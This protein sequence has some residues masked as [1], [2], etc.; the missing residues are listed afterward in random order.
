[1]AVVAKLVELVDLVEH[2]VMALP[3]RDLEGMEHCRLGLVVVGLRLHRGSPME[4]LEGLQLTKA[5]RDSVV[6]VVGR[7]VMEIVVLAVERVVDIVVV[8]VQTVVRMVLVVVPTTQE[9]VSQIR[10]APIPRT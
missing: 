8:V 3:E 7:G 2:K 9:R 1:M 10:P 6:S 5:R 4:E